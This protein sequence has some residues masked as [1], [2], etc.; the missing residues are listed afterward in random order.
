[1]AFDPISAIFEVG[2]KL[3]EKLIPDPQKAAEATHLARHVL[4]LGRP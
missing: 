2:G 1:M 3:I 4:R